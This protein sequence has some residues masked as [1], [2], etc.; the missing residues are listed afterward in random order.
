MRPMIQQLK[1]KKDLMGVEIG[2]YKGEYTKTIFETLNIKTLYGI[3]PYYRYINDHGHPINYIK[4]RKL[5]LEN[6]KQFGDKFIFIEKTSGEARK[7]I[8]NDLDF[9]Y[10]D[11]NHNY[12]YVKGDIDIYYDKIKNNGV[13]GGDDYYHRHP[14]VIYAVNEFVYENNLMLHTYPFQHPTAKRQYKNGFVT[15]YDW[16]IIKGENSSNIDYPDKVIRVEK[17]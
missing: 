10:I 8:P 9:V 5:M 3:D 17:K 6:T 11:G 1:N 7:E 12:E 13:I 4:W 16:W 2:L 14:G 15:K